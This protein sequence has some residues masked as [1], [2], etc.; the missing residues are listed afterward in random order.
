MDQV[1]AQAKV[2]IP[3]TSKA[4]DSQRAYEKRLTT[5]MSKEKGLYLL[6]VIEFYVQYS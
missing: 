2:E 3:A 5:A 1:L 6:N 4:W